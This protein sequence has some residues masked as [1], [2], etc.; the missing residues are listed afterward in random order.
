MDA[1]TQPEDAKKMTDNSTGPYFHLR[2][3]EVIEETADAKSIVLEIPEE[4]R[5]RFAYSAGQFLTFRVDVNGHRIVRCYSLASSPVIDKAHK[6]AVKRVVDGRMSNWMNDHVAVGTELEVMPPAGHFCLRES[7]APIVLFG[8]GS[9]ITPIISIIKTA[10]ATTSRR[11]KLVYANRDDKSIIFKDELSAL[12]AANLDQ[13]EIVHRLDD[14]HGFVDEARVVQEIGPLEN[15]DFYICGPGPFMDVVEKALGSLGV[16]AEQVFIE[17]FE[18]PSEDPLAS[19]AP[20]PG[21]GQPVKIKLDGVETEIVVAEGETV[22]AAARRSGLE[23]PFACEEAYCG[24]CMA[25]VVSGDVEMQMNDG[26]INQRQIDDGWILTCQGLVKS[27][28]S[29]EY[30]D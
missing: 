15:A 27:P 7:D 21:E 8:G 6:V 3:A 18:S 4:L 12:H 13:L 26:G 11:I 9:G 20:A 30:P 10:L 17:R 25:K 2:V 22:L 1:Q 14:L 23:P 5:E 16:G 24:C 29:I 19:A 28:A